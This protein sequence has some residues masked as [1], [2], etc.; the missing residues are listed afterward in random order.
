[1][2]IQDMSFSDMLSQGLQNRLNTATQPFTDPSGYITNRI[3]ADLGLANASPYTSTTNSDQQ[4]QLN[5]ISPANATLQNQQPQQGMI[6]GGQ[7]NPMA[8]Q[9]LG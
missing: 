3:G 2:A 5:T 6:P 9:P 7:M 8:G 4:N 1:M